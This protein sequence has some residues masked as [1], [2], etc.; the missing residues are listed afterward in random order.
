M[1]FTIK[2]RFRKKYKVSLYND[3]NKF[4][5]WGVPSYQDVVLNYCGRDGH[6]FNETRYGLN[7][8]I[9]PNM[10][11]FDGTSMLTKLTPGLLCNAAN[12]TIHFQMIPSGTFATQYPIY[13]ENGSVAWFM[14]T[15]SS[16]TALTIYRRGDSGSLRSVSFTTPTFVAGTEY[17]ISIRCTNS[18]AFDVW[19]NGSKLTQQT[20]VAT[21]T[22]TIT[23]LTI[24]CYS[25]YYYQGLLHELFIYN[26]ALSDTNVL[27]FNLRI[28]DS[29]NLASGF[30]FNGGRGIE[31]DLWGNLGILSWYKGG[32]QYTGNL[33]TPSIV[34]S[35]YFLDYGF[36]FYWKQDSYALYMPFTVNSTVSSVLSTLG[37]VLIRQI[38]G[39]LTILPV[40]P[41]CMIDFD[42]LGTG[43]SILLNFNRSNVTIYNSLARYGI[44]YDV[45][46]PYRFL[47]SDVSDIEIY[48]GWKN[49]GYKK[50]ISKIDWVYDLKYIPTRL[51][52]LV[53]YSFDYISNFERLNLYFDV[54]AETGDISIQLNASGLNNNVNGDTGSYLPTPLLNLYNLQYAPDQ[55]M[56]VNK[57]YVRKLSLYVKSLSNV[58]SFKFYVWRKVST[59]WSQQYLIELLPLLSVGANTI[60]LPIPVY[61]EEQDYVGFGYE[62]SS[63]TSV[64]AVGYIKNAYDVNETT[65]QYFSTTVPAVT[66]QNWSGKTGYATAPVV[67]VHGAKPKIVTMGDSVI[68]SAFIT[69]KNQK[70]IGKMAAM[71]YRITYLHRANSG[72]MMYTNNSYSIPYKFE[73]DVV[74]VKPDIAIINGGI[75]DMPSVSKVNFIAGWTTIFELCRINNIIPVVWLM[76]P[77]ETLT[78]AQM[79]D[80]DDWNLSLQNLANTYSNSIVINLSLSMAQ[81]RSG[82]DVGNLWDWRDA[83]RREV[84]GS[85][86]HQNAAGDTKMAELTYAA[87]SNLL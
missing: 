55:Q 46:H 76:M 78:N 40:L 59:T 2:Q 61:I 43:N 62:T 19:I 33:F 35:T 32:I 42:P 80:W 7:A 27:K 38:F 66:G 64:I 56:Y 75:N 1:G 71:D 47:L 6:T 48:N 9:F 87:I 8:S 39:G 57:G 54:P 30:I 12:F 31:V 15:I 86:L 13:Y 49:I 53:M 84:Y 85:G 44:D 5:V 20:M 28:F 26:V 58:T 29:E 25:P 83:Y 52:Q 24:G 77:K 69:A 63:A 10:A 34:G 17:R 51:Q 23:T 41:F 3:T 74:P 50:F 60:T 79:R 37:Y 70:W 45:T 67:H 82:G 22:A 21:G 73:R 65:A 11:K 81:F 4:D 72:Q 68:T 36:S 18:I 14:I 16:A